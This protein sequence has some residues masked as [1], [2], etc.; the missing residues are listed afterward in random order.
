M[1]QFQDLADLPEDERIKKIGLIAVSEPG[2][3]LAVIVDGIMGVSEDKANRYTRKLVTAYPTI[4]EIER[5]PGPVP[6]SIKLLYIAS[7]APQ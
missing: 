4:R 3:R 6:D 5:G 1:T 2:R 7:R